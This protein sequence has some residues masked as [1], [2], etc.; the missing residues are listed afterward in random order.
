MEKKHKA[1][2]LISCLL[3]LVVVATCICWSRISTEQTQNAYLSMLE[4]ARAHFADFS[5]SKDSDS[6]TKGKSSFSEATALLY[7]SGEHWDISEERETMMAVTTLL[8]SSPSVVEENMDSLL[9][10]LDEILAKPFHRVSY[11]KLLSFFN[12]CNHE[13]A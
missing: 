6:Y 11:G 4:D 7:D 10:A 1:R 9:M 2:M 13:D 3:I 12:G 5:E 8:E